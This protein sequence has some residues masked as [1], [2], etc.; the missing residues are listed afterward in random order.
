MRIYSAVI[1]RG[2]TLAAGIGIAVPAMN[3]PASG[4]LEAEIRTTSYGVAHIVAKDLAGVGFGQGYALASTD[5]CEIAGRWVTVNAQ[6]S[7]Y[8]GEDDLLPTYGE[9]STT[10]NLQSDF[11]WEWIIDGDVIGR[12]LR[13]APP[14]GPTAEVREIVR[15]YVAGYNLYLRKT[16]VDKLPDARCRGAAW[17]RPITEKDVYLRALHWS[18]FATSVNSATQFVSAMPPSGG[19]SGAVLPPAR[20]APARDAVPP[21]DRVGSNMIALGKDATDNG[22]GMLFANPHWYWNGPERFFESQITIPGKLNVYGISTLGLPMILLGETEHVAWSHTVSTPIR[23]TV[24][25][26]QLAPNDPT[27][28]L[29]DGKVQKL[30]SREVRVGDRTHR[31]WETPY[32]LVMQDSTFKWTDKTAFALRDVTMSLSW[33]NKSMALDHAQ[34]IEE[35][36]AAG[37]RYL[38]IPWLNT[39]AADSSGHV[40]YTDDT[41]VPNVTDAMLDSCVTSALGKQLLPSRTVV[42]DGWRSACAWGSDADS[43]QPG[44]FGASKLPQ[45]ART[46][47]VTNSNDSYWTNNPHHLLEGYPKV[48][49]PERTMRTLRTRIGLYK[50]E[51]RLSGKD[52]Y[53]GN[54]FTLD[55]LQAITMNNQVLSGE[56]WRDAAVSMCRQLPD[57]DKAAEAC[58]V[59]AKWNLAENLDSHGAVLWRRFFEI[60]TGKAGAWSEE[61]APDLFAVPFDPNDPMNTPR[62]LNTANPR[63]PAA[64]IAAV[65]DL[66]K[67]GIPI[68]ASLRAYQYVDRGGRRIAIP[69]GPGGAGQYDDIEN[70]DGWVSPRGWPDV[71]AGSSYIM[72]TQFTDNGPHGHSILTYSQSNNPDSPHHAD[73]TRLFSEGKSKAILFTDAEIAADAN[74]SVV[75][76]S[77]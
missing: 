44:T 39:I 14:R 3:A 65:A 77:D 34:S 28:Y 74:L 32:G 54:R 6:R 36:K 20:L 43:I 64:L 27:S 50:L 42:L 66:R 18:L 71:F 53:P 16:G 70:K 68:D 33:M 75:K 58:E 73:Q 25:Q 61:V 19:T 4:A 30:V 29:Y 49:G 13:E 55:D 51:R 38:G 59:L 2:V 22:R 56:L 35:V 69:G 47:Y 1:L 21:R 57:T 12:E 31:F 72:W 5:I 46:D 37:R 52:G 76:I 41:A 40:L 17:V 10:T 63:V 26:L 60:L 15:G 48:M 23:T 11:F 8:F 24:Y 9:R 62:G 67:A 7:R 45:L